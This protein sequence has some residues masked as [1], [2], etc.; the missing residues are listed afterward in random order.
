MDSINTIWISTVPRT[1]SAWILNA[2]KEI[3]K[4][5]IFDNCDNN[6]LQ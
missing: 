5:Y 6:T 2:T 3:L 1:G 4:T